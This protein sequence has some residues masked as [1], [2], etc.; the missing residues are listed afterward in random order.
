MVTV[1]PLESGTRQ[2][3]PCGSSSGPP[4]LGLRGPRVLSRENEKASGPDSPA[5]PLCPPAGPYHA[6]RTPPCRRHPKAVVGCGSEP[7]S[8]VLRQTETRPRATHTVPEPLSCSKG[9]ATLCPITESPQQPTQSQS[10]PSTLLQMAPPEPRSGTGCP[11]PPEVPWASPRDLCSLRSH[12]RPGSV[13]GLVAPGGGVVPGL[14]GLF[15]G[16]AHFPLRTP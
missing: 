8:E 5:R 11:L 4:S 16:T 2:A 10:W 14:S 7:T 1:G 15:Q 9:T 12:R 13:P 3:C 6:H